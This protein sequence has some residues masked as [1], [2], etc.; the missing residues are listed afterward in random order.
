M[1]YLRDENEFRMMSNVCDHCVVPVVD[2]MPYL[3]DDDVDGKMLLLVRAVLLL[4]S[5]L[6]YTSFGGFETI[7]LFA[8]KISHIYLIW[9]FRN[10]TVND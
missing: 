1:V 8:C 5:D 9:I 10:K 3:V 4:I 6:F 2:R 7:F